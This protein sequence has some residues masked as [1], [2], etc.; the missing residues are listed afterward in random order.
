M[1]WLNSAS[2]AG[3]TALGVS[4]SRHQL[5]LDGNAGDRLENPA[6]LTRQSKTVVMNGATYDVYHN[7]VGFAQVPVN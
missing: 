7:S 3:P 5:I 2:A 6:G 4:E 1:N